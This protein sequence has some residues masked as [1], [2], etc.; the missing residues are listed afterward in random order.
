MAENV[1]CVV[2]AGNI[3]D[4]SLIARRIGEL[5]LVTCATPS[6]LQRYGEPRHPTDLEKDHYVVSYFSTRTAQSYPMSF[7]SGDETFEITGR[8]VVALNDGNAY[9]AAALLGMGVAQAPTFMVQ[10]H[11]A[12]GTLRPVLTDWSCEIMPLH[13]VY[14]PNRH[15]SNKVRVFV[16]WIADVF[17]G[18]ELIRRRSSLRA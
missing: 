15:L 9:L 13:V 14:P 1:D 12:A 18:N 5:Q 7:R 2:R 10:E 6:Y 3:T 16:D 8:S 4:Q 11:L 17:A